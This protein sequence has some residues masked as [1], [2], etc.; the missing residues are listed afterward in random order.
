VRNPAVA[1]AAD[2]LDPYH[3][4]T[5]DSFPE[6]SMP[7][8]HSERRSLHAVAMAIAVLSLATVS[9]APRATQTAAGS[10][11][12]APETGAFIVRLGDD[13]V[14]VERFTRT[15]DRVE[16]DIVL[17]SPARIGH[18]VITLGPDG[19]PT[20]AEYTVR[21]PDGS[22]VPNAPRA[23]S[24]TFGSDTV[25]SVVM[26][27]TAITRRLA[28]RSAFPAAGLSSAMVELALRNVVASGRDS[29]DLVM[30]GFGAQSPSTF[31]VRVFRP[32]SARITW[33]GGSPQYV[34]LDRGGRIVAL[35]ATPT[36]FKVKVDRLPNVD[37]PAVASAF[38][39]AEE[40]GR[41]LVMSVRDT[42]RATVGRANLLVD[43]GRPLRR[44]RTIFGGVVPFD[45]I[46]RTGANAATQLRT[47]A[48]L[49]MGGV[50]IPAGTYTLW[51]IP[52]R[53][54]SWKLVINRQTGQWGTV[55]DPARDLAR[56]DLQTQTVDTPVERFTITIE[57]QGEGGLLAL[58][59]DRMRASVPFTVK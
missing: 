47:D 11:I 57:P 42:V 43:Y 59:W 40:G 50:T 13:T 58:A 14:A 48:D 4:G 18:Y 38:A 36:T 17:R 21:R 44:G 54:G 35:D 30:V 9:C 51:T 22:L 29:A 1:L 8:R 45:T 7:T 46:W 31:P 28:A 23:A 32:D 5:G 55:Y 33:F 3:Q 34:R 10:A 27:D 24:L 49:V 20:R 2:L 37:V 26:L 41:R 12:D 15:A 6:V 56:I 52:S 16:G 25:V 39:A 19:R 53:T